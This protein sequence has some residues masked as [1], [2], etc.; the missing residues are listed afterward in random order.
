MIA[1]SSFSHSESHENSPVI[2]AISSKKGRDH[3]TLCSFAHNPCNSKR[4]NITLVR[5]NLGEST[6]LM[7]AFDG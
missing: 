7:C 4:L 1:A 6:A 2:I 3:A 5:E